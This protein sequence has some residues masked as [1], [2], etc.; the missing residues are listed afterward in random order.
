[1]CREDKGGNLK[2]PLPGELRVFI[3]G[4]LCPEGIVKKMCFCAVIHEGSVL[5]LF[6]S[7][8]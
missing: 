2:L 8:R 6:T 3:S 4:V 7:Q 1:M 5:C